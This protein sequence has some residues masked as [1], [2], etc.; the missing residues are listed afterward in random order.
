MNDSGC[1]AGYSAAETIQLQLFYHIKT[2]MTLNLHFIVNSSCE[3]FLANCTSIIASLNI[4]SFNRIIE[5]SCLWYTTFFHFIFFSNFMNS[6]HKKT[7]SLGFTIYQGQ[8]WNYK[9]GKKGL[10]I[11]S[12]HLRAPTGEDIYHWNWNC[13][14]LSAL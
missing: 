7:P 3:D 10:V 13:T 11:I 14:C 1:K 12:Q 8:V 2:Q 6:C 5:F 9:Y 4:T